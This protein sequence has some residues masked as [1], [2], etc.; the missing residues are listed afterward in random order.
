MFDF[1]FIHNM[2]EEERKAWDEQIDEFDKKAEEHERQY[3]F[4]NCGIGERYL[5]ESFETF[6][7]R[8]EDD[9][10]LLKSMKLFSQ[11]IKTGKYATVKLLGKVGTGKTHLAAAVLRE[12]GGMYRVIDVIC[13]EV[14]E[15]ERFDVK[16]DIERVIRRYVNASFL[17]LDEIGRSQYPEREKYILYRIINGRYE[18]RLPTLLISNFD[19]MK[20][21]EFVGAATTDRLNE[22]CQTYELNG[23]SYRIKKRGE[24]LPRV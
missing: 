23:T 12:C 14:K 15:A 19:K 2:T 8:T 22:N 11:T 18:K 24:E 16:D 4:E 6:D 5:K 21:A 10:A 7:C 9:K 17:V 13:N 1:S 3:R 20:F